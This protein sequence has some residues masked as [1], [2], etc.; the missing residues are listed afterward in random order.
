MASERAAEKISFCFGQLPFE[1][2][3]PLDESLRVRQVPQSLRGPPGM[4]T[5][6]AQLAANELDRGRNADA[7]SFEGSRHG[8]LDEG[9]ERRVLAELNRRVIGTHP[10]LRMLMPS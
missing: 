7:A 6:G 4:I 3:L 8:A 2:R 9:G 5:G 1:I 10:I